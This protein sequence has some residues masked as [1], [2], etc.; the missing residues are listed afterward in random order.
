MIGTLDFVLGVMMKKY[1]PSKI[2][3]GGQTGADYGGL[4]AAKS[5]GIETGG[6]APLRY[7]TEEGP[8]KVLKYLYYL[9]ESDS[10]SYVPRTEQ[11]I[12][13]SDATLIFAENVS[14]SGTKLTIKF[15]IKHNKPY[16]VY[17]TYCSDPRSLLEF[18]DKHKP[19]VINVAGNRESVA[20]GI[21][22]EVVRVLLEVLE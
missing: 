14:S 15:C 18:L 6:M 16:Y 20:P 10:Y 22:K 21:C 12:I 3:S 4:K 5:L 17:D 11:N 9:E 2:I 19:S 7:R 1:K 8:K 13:D